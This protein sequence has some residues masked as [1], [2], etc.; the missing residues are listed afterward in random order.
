MAT[1]EAERNLVANLDVQ[2]LHLEREIPVPEHSLSALRAHR[3]LAQARLDSYKYPV[4]MLPN[5]IVS[6]IFVHFLPVYPKP[7]PLAGTLSPTTL[8]HICRKWRNIALTTPTLWR[9]AYLSINEEDEIADSD[10]FIPFDQQL[11]ELDVWLNRSRCCPLSIE[12]EE[13]FDSPRNFFFPSAQCAR[14]EYLWVSLLF[15]PFLAIAGPL[16]LLRHLDIL[17]DEPGVGDP[18]VFPEAPLLRSVILN[19]LALETVILPWAQ[20]TSLTLHCVFPHECVPVLQ[21][22]S[23]LVDCQLYLVSST[24]PWPDVTLPRLESL[25]LSYSKPENTYLSIF[26]ARRAC[27]VLQGLVTKVRLAVKASSLHRPARVQISHINLKSFKQPYKGEKGLSGLVRPYGY[28]ETLITPALRELQIDENLLDVEDPIHSLTSFISKSGCKLREMYISG[29]RNVSQDLYS[30]AFPS[31]RLSFDEKYDG[32]GADT[33][34]D[35][36][37]ASSEADV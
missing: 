15:Q 31:V 24:G 21:Q 10:I 7:A 23:N 4:L 8:T 29:T 25:T 19:D 12:I 35:S 37:T 33:T 14:W 1:L 28:L 36:D 26:C 17:V 20:L 6:E 30:R 34:T 22:T 13:T 2:I 9:A 18:V 32:E 3:T 5:E 16:P 27:Q 11:H